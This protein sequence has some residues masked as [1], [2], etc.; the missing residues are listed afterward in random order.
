VLKPTFSFSYTNVRDVRR[1]N[2]QKTENAFYEKIKT[3]KT[4]NKNVVCKIIPTT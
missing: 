4:L 2:Q 3:L 1:K